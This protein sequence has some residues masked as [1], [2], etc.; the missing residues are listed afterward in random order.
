MPMSRVELLL[1]FS[2][3]TFDLDL[4]SERLGVQSTE[5]WRRS[6]SRV[7]NPEGLRD[8]CSWSFSSTVEGVYYGNIIDAFL[9]QFFPD[10]SVVGDV[11]EQSAVEAY[12]ILKR[13]G[14]EEDYAP[15]FEDHQTLA[16]IAAMRTR[17]YIEGDS[18][19]TD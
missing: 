4:V 8:R 14:P 6:T 19:R 9:D 16:R 2:P 3:E 7:R 1:W 11:V 15:G 12:L 18:R 13:M 5:V 10:P 17:L